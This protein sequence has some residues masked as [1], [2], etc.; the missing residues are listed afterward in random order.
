[1]ITAYSSSRSEPTTSVDEVPWLRI[2]LLRV[3]PLVG[4]LLVVAFGLISHAEAAHSTATS[5]LA[6]TNSWRLD[7][8]ATNGEIEGYSHTVSG[9]PGDALALSVSTVDPYYGIE[10]FRFG[11]YQGGQA[12]LVW[13]SGQLQ[14]IQQ[15]APAFSSYDTRTVDAD[16]PTSVVIPTDG[17]AAGVYLLKLTSAYG[18]ESYVPYIVRSTSTTGTVTLVAPVTTWQAYNDWGGYSLYVGANGDRN[19]WA[20]SFDRPYAAP[21]SADFIYGV[22]PV[23]LL[24]ERTGLPLSYLATTDI[25][26]NPTIVQDS[27][28]VVSMGHSEYWTRAMRDSLTAARD[29]GTN[30]AFLG[31]NNMYWQIRLESDA[32]SGPG[33]LEVGYKWDAKSDPEYNTNPGLVTNRW[34]DSPSPEPENSLIGLLYECHPANTDYRVVSPDWWGFRNTGVA[35]G[36]TFPHLVG[37]EADRAYLTP[38]TPHPLQVLSFMDYSCRGS[39]TS[40]QSTYYTT[41]SGAGVFTA[42]TLRWTCAIYQPCGS[43]GLTLETNAFVRRVTRNILKVFAKGPAGVQHPAVDNVDQFP[44]PTS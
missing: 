40:S 10:A 17:W 41:P 38:T 37:I 23:V 29:A 4:V 27:R 25:D 5:E 24:A 12:T 34:R 13:S 36:T 16:W 30:L 22:K 3:A 14:G 43:A 9:A 19:S 6:G 1:V 2:A 20:V 15:P 44:L 11:A 18:Y 39:P 26:S 35:T 7:R 32:T 8:P 21:G 28:A 33:R 31:A 42:G